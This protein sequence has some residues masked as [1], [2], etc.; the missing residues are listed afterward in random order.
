MAKLV[1]HAGVDDEFLE[2]Y[3]WYAK[4]SRPAAEKFKALVRQALD[5]VIADPMGGAAYDDDHR[6]YRLKKYPHLVIYRYSPED[7]VATIVAV[8]H[9]SQD[10][11]Y[12]RNR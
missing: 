8:S 5:R 3:L 10:Q 11:S 4:R 6:F 12:W 9:P 1:I 2:A 7:N